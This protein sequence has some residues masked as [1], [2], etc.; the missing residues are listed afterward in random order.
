MIRV[1][2]TTGR[3][4]KNVLETARQRIDTKIKQYFQKNFPRRGGEVEWIWN[5]EVTADKADTQR[6]AELVRNALQQL[7]FKEFNAAKNY[8]LFA[9]RRDGSEDADIKAGEQTIHI[10]ALKEFTIAHKKSRG[11][12]TSF[13]TK[14]GATR[15]QLSGSLD[16][17]V[18]S[19]TDK[20]VVSW[21]T[22]DI[23]ERLLQFHE[24]VP[25]NRQVPRPALDI[26]CYALEGRLNKALSGLDSQVYDGL[27]GFASAIRGL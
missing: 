6:G 16:L 11:Q 22:G 15:S 26:V 8:M 20:F 12:S 21:D 4:M 24:G 7:I 27:E 3:F 5:F 23:P 2:V 1:T 18:E 14:T 13:L 17:K 19:D 9:L 10:A 25:A